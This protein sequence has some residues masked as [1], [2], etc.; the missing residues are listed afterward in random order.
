VFLISIYF[1]SNADEQAVDSKPTGNVAKV[2]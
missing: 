1:I 2:C